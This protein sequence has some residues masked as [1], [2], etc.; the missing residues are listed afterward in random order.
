MPPRLDE[1]LGERYPVVLVYKVKNVS[2]LPTFATATD[3]LRQRN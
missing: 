1:Q 3:Q 2:H